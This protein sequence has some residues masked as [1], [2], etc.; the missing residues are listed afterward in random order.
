MVGASQGVKHTLLHSL[1][2]ELSHWE[3]TGTAMWKF[4]GS[5]SP[6]QGS[7]SVRQSLPH[8]I[9]TVLMTSAGILLSYRWEGR[10]GRKKLVGVQPGGN[11][12]LLHLLRPL[13][14]AVDLFLVCAEE[15]LP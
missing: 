14:P 8:Q 12:L 9:L 13:C 1:L 7:L 11:S 2:L 3:L 6:H 4:C 15:E 5:S 10:T